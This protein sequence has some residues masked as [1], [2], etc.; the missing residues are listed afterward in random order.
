MSKLVHNERVK[1]QATFFNN[2]GI[3][4]FV[5]AIFIPTMEGL[6]TQL[7][8]SVGYIVSGAVV[9]LLSHFFGRLTLRLLQ[10]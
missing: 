4:L 5:G 1:L 10:E 3:A 9:C 6:H 8:S 7:W 2:V